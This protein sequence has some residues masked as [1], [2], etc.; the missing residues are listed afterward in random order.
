MP[1]KTRAARPDDPLPRP[2]ALALRPFESVWVGVTLLTLLLIYL[3]VGSALPFVR[4][5][6]L[7]EMTEFEWFNWWPF[8]LLGALLAVNITIVTV[9]RIP[10]NLVKLGVWMI[11][12]GIVLL[13]VT[14]WWYFAAKVEG[15]APVIRRMVE[16]RAPSGE[17]ARFPA[18][19]GASA[20][21]GGYT[22]RVSNLDPAWPILSGEHEGEE[23]FSVSVMI[24][25]PAGVNGGEPFVRQMLAGYEQYTEDVLPGR[26]RAVK[27]TGKKLVDRD[28]GMN[29]ALAPQEWYH[30]AQTRALFVREVGAQEWTELPVSGLPR[31][32]DYSETP[33]RDT[34]PAPGDPLPPAGGIRVDIPGFADA[35]GAAAVATGFLRY[36]IPQER[37][38]P[39]GAEHGPGAVL[40]VTGP[41]GQ[42]NVI[43]LAPGIEGY[44]ISS[45]GALA[46]VTIE[47]AAALEALIER[48]TPVITVAAGGASERAPVERT[49]VDDPALGFTP[50][51]EAGFTY[52]VRMV[53]DGLRMP[54][55][56]ELSAAI[57]EL[58]TPE[59]D[60][61]VRLVSAD[62][63]LVQDI[64]SRAD[65]ATERETVDDRITVTYEPGATPAAVT[66][67][68]GPEMG[69][70]AAMLI[71]PTG[72]AP[73][74]VPA[75]K[76]EDVPLPAGGTGRVLELYAHARAETRPA[77]VPKRQRDRSAGEHFSM[78]QVEIAGERRWLPYHDYVFDGPAFRYAGRFKHEPA[79]FE[80]PGGRA[81]EVIYSRERERLPAPVALQ[82]F[83]L[84]SFVGGFT[85][86]TPTIRDWISD[87]RFATDSGW[88]EPM[89]VATN[90]PVRYEGLSFFQAMWD[91]P[92]RTENGPVGGLAFTG[93]GVGSRDGAMAMLA[94]SCLSV[95][96]MI[97][98]FY[99]KPS[100]QRSRVK[101]ALAANG[102]EAAAS[103]SEV[104][105]TLSETEEKTP[106]EVGA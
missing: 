65:G 27:T 67:V 101:R 83:H 42:K 104:K 32:N 80:L 50:V 35:A 56:A 55:G 63:G 30:L 79:V 12:A 47:S 6:R 82:D 48:A 87:V 19:P 23:A 38:V 68:L 89:A 97:Y 99:V 25:P 22:F 2:L 37:L 106:V 24:E 73:A 44:E 17:T 45:N 102:A 21:A 76:G 96:G 60:E 53:A 40:E 3:S 98:V 8:G 70:D 77:V 69:E 61:F 11:H 62:G 29:L 84:E 54:G 75:G 26:G 1:S 95:A 9:R 88:T 39:A 18:L 43:P 31:Y 59:G 52:R 66:L 28:L 105:P 64:D 103:E 36:A 58:R 57:V 15:D 85:G 51:G 4:E 91:P 34:W 20:S 41:E 14:S 16:A 78:L 86:A 33:Q 71:A 74:L 72:S 100:I 5:S 46:A 10:F 90:A 49:S 92:Q 7:F 94:S 81:V 93:L 13:I